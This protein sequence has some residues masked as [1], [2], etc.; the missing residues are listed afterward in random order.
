MLSYPSAPYPARREFD[1]TVPDSKQR[2]AK[3]ADMLAVYQHLTSA[4]QVA[5]GRAIGVER[6]WLPRQREA[7]LAKA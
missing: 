7:A 4:E 2:R 6:V 5:F 1:L 3:I